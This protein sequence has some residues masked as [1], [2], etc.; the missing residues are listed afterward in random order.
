MSQRTWTGAEIDTLRRLVEACNDAE[1][2]RV[3][4]RTMR[5]VKKARLRM[6]IIRSEASQLRMRARDQRG[7]KNPNWKGGRSKKP[8]LYKLVQKE[9]HPERV[10]ARDR[11]H[12]AVRSGRLQRQPCEVCGSEEVEAHHDDYSQPLAV[13]WLCREHHRMQH[14][15]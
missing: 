10:A 2:G 9:R 15:A 13:R 5:A 8:Y 12:R 1:I 3:L 11:V 14:A 7:D 6:G 4:G